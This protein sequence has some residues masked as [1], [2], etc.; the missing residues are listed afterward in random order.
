MSLAGLTDWGANPTL[1]AMIRFAGERQRLIAHNIANIS[2]PNFVQS[3]LSPGK[4][5]AQLRE[6]VE[7]RRKSGDTEPLRLESSEE[8]T[9]EEDGTL[10]FS[11]ENSGGNVLGH[12]RNN[13]DLERLMQDQAENLIVFRQAMDLLR[14]R[15]E[16]MRSALA[17]RV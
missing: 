1:E 11:P 7:R 13:L 15:S 2:T 10:E 8:V 9:P 14:S 16:L 17:Q 5:Q 6:A 3:D 12:D 4:F